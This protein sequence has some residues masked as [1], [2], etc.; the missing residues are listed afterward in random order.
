M[1]DLTAVDQ[2]VEVVR[3]ETNTLALGG[4]GGPM[5]VPQQRLA[6]RTLYL[7]NR[8]EGHVMTTDALSLAASAAIT[9]AQFKG[10][11]I[12]VPTDTKFEA[13]IVLTLPASAQLANGDRCVIVAVPNPLGDVNN[14]GDFRLLRAGADTII[15]NG[16]PI[17][18]YIKIRGGD[19]VIIEKN[20][21]NFVIT[22][23]VHNDRVVARKYNNDEPF[24][25]LGTNGTD[26]ISSN[27]YLGGPV[28]WFQLGITRDRQL[29]MYGT[30][31]VIFDGLTTINGNTYK[32]LFTITDANMIPTRDIY[33]KCGSGLMDGEQMLIRSDGKVYFQHAAGITGDLV[34]LDNTIVNLI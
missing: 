16:L 13:D 26:I 5:N 9:A 19:Q 22:G 8:H 18:G 6:D 7:K 10:G 15:Y 1:T 11:L 27:L 31:T 21:A 32:L 17:S 33:F 14:Q 2:W 24:F 12:L 4:A 30:L 23:F 20:D 3:L 34:D 29:R 25:T 28:A